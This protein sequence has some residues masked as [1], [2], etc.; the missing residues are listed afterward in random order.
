MPQWLSS[1]HDE[2]R[3]KRA[4]GSPGDIEPVG[5]RRRVAGALYMGPK[6]VRTKP[7]LSWKPERQPCPLP[8]IRGGSDYEGHWPATSE[9]STASIPASLGERLLTRLLE[10]WSHQPPM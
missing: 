1:Q 6:K 9:A 7:T 10:L 3:A 2:H 8:E 5:T 4:G